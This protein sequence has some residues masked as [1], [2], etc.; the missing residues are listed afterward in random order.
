MKKF[1]IP[2]VVVV[3]LLIVGVLV[4]GNS[5]N[6][7]VPPIDPPTNGGSTNGGSIEP[8]YPD[9]PPIDQTWISPG[10]VIIANFYPG[11]RAEWVLLVHNGKDTAATFEVKY[12]LPDRVEDGYVEANGEQ[13]DWIIIADPTP[14]IEPQE[15]KEILIAVVMPA[16]AVAPGPKWEFWISVKDTTQAGMV[17]TELCSRWLVAMRV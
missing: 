7:G 5:S 1:I 13:E 16:D 8:I 9:N 3:G 2:I 15:T 4:F 10:K 17:V 12:R 11:A 14:V 6:G